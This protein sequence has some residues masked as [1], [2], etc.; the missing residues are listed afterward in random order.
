MSH[1][2]VDG[3]APP[4]SGDPSGWLGGAGQWEHPTLRRAVVHGVRLYNG[5]EHHE[6]AD[7]FEHEWYNYGSGTVESKFLHGMVQLAAGAYK[8]FY[9]ENSEARSASGSRTQSGDDDGMAR[10]F[11]T[12]LTYLRG[13]PDDFYGVDVSVVRKLLRDV[14]DDPTALEDG[15]IR[16]DGAYPTTRRVDREFVESVHD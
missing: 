11:E 2:Q 13:V 5:G 1:T 16:L 15:R 4:D 6:S 10:L 8:H 9:F 7:C 14:L 3:V 12:S